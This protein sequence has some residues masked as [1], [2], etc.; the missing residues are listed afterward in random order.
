[1]IMK[2]QT[3]S[4]SVLAGAALLCLTAIAGVASGEAAWTVAGVLGFAALW[5]P[6][7]RREPKL[8]PVRICSR[9]HRS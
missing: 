3:N 2:Q 5:L 4:K 9:N 7:T 8:A 1:M 6:A